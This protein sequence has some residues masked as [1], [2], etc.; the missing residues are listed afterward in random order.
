MRAMLLP[1]ATFGL[2]HGG[3]AAGREE[4]RKRLAKQLGEALT[5]AIEEY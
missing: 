5:K 2:H 3:P 4:E 1:Y